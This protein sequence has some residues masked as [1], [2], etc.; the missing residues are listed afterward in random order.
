[1]VDFKNLVFSTEVI[2]EYCLIKSEV[3]INVKGLIITL[4]QNG[5]N[6]GEPTQIILK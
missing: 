4:D 2:T 5:R 1:M 6:E 3:Y